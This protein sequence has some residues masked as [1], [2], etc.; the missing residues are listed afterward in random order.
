M[1]IWLETGESRN[2]REKTQTSAGKVMASISWDAKGIIFIDYLEK[3]KTIT[4]KYYAS[5][6]DRL[7]DEIKKKRPHLPKEKIPYHHGNSP[8]HSSLKATGK[9]IKLYE[10]LPHPPYSPD[11]APT[12]YYLFPSL[13]RWLEGRRFMSNDEVIAEVDAYFEEFDKS[14]YSKGI[15]MLEDRYTKCISLDGNYVEE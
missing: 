1:A 12:D 13:K 7:N 15:E 14:Y 3:G 4:G 9:L 2:K 6:L 10:L 8:A 11:L 5:L